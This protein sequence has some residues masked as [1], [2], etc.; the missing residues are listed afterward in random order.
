MVFR[1]SRVAAVER[2]LRRELHQLGDDDR[3]EHGVGHPKAIE[4]QVEG[5]NRQPRAG[6]EDVERDPRGFEVDE[7][8]AFV[9]RRSRLFRIAHGDGDVEDDFG[10]NER[11]DEREEGD[12][13]VAFAR[14]VDLDPDD[15]SKP[16]AAEQQHA[17]EGYPGAFFPERH[18][19]YC[20]TYLTVCQIYL[21]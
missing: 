10:E 13:R 6:H 12:H 17:A 21:T 8:L 19:R 2:D 11:A 20:Q 5:A 9:S 1:M 16:E 15:V 14:V 7:L 3:A 4:I 18:A